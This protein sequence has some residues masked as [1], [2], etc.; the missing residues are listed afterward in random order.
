MDRLVYI[1]DR[2]DAASGMDP[3]LDD[4][5]LGEMA[6]IYNPYREFRLSGNLDRKNPQEYAKIIRQ[7]EERI[8]KYLSG[9]GKL[10]PLDLRFKEIGGGD[11]WVMVEEIGAQARTGMLRKGVQAFVSVR[12]RPDGRYTYSL[13]RISPFIT[14]FDLPRLIEVL[15]KEEKS[16]DDKWGGSNIIGGSPRVNGSKFSP[17]EVEE[18]INNCLAS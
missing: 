10:L 11:G 4:R 5:A 17:E 1:S 18:I 8:I 3:S 15:N 14:N 9:K 2:L 12:Q 16:Q 7:I 6:W 13:G